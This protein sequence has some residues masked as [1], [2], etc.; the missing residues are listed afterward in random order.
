M[1]LQS[2]DKDIKDLE[3]A[4]KIIEKTENYMQFKK[5]H[6]IFEICEQISVLNDKKYRQI[7]TVNKLV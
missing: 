4:L 5:A 6:L 7:G 2:I 3:K 1:N